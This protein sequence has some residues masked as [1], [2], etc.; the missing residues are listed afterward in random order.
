MLIGTNSDEIMGAMDKPL[1]APVN[2]NDLLQK[3]VIEHACRAGCR[4]HHL[5]E[6]GESVGLAQ[7][8]ERFGAQAYPYEEYRLERLPVSRLDMG[9]RGVVKRAIGFKDA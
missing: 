5:G 2:A 6:S 3:A 4:Y 9:L 7:F 1:A 8:K